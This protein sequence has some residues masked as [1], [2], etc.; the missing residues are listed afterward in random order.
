MLIDSQLV[1]LTLFTLSLS[2]RADTMFVP[3][4]NDFMSCL[5]ERKTS[6]AWSTCWQP[7]LSGRRGPLGWWLHG[8]PR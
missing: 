2:L 3:S 6:W 1:Q 7:Q 8:R 4:T 5:P